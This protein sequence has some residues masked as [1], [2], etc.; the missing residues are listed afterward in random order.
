MI[1]TQEHGKKF[2]Y[3][4]RALRGQ[5]GNNLGNLVESCNKDIFNLRRNQTKWFKTIPLSKL[6][7]GKFYLI[8]YNYDGNSLYCPIFI[9]DYRITEKG[10]HVVYAINLDYLPF[11]YKMLYFNRMSTIFDQIFDKNQDIEDFTQEKQIPVNFEQIY[12]KTVFCLRTNA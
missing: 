7:L 2:E 11:D 10:K 6:Q 4:V 3:Y 12:K 5:F 1:I 8:L 9:I